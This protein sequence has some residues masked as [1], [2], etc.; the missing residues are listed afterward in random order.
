MDGTTN[1]LTS[2]FAAAQGNTA[3]TGVSRVVH[4]D[5]GVYELGLRRTDEQKYPN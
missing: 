1:G 5:D 2:L 4:N 3:N